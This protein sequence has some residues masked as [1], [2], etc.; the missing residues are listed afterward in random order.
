MPPVNFKRTQQLD[1]YVCPML[2]VTSILVLARKE[3][4][5]RI[6]S[7]QKVCVER[8]PRCFSFFLQDRAGLIRSYGRHNY[9]LSIKLLQCRVNQRRTHSWHFLNLWCNV[10]TLWGTTGNGGFYGGPCRGVIRRTTEARIGNGFQT[11]AH[12]CIWLY[13]KIMHAIGRSHTKSCKCKYSEHMTRRTPT[14][15]I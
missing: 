7:S 1:V 13:S 8:S 10:H 15:E 11:S 14:Q 6:V 3:A 2:L 4:L 9:L 12:T 5:L